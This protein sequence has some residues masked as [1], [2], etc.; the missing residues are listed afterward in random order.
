MDMNYMHQEKF[1]KWKNFIIII[2]SLLF[3]LLFYQQNTGGNFLL[4]SIITITLLA[5]N[6]YKSFFKSDILL[7]SVAFL[8]SGVAI[9]LYNSP[10]T[11]ITNILV[12]FTLVGSFY[13]Q[14]SS[15]YI[16]WINGMYTTLVAAFTL[17]FEKLHTETNNIKKK[18]TNYFYWIKTIGIPAIIVFIFMNLYKTGNPKFDA[19]LSQINFSFINFQCLVFTSLGYYLFYNITHPVSIE[20]A[21]TLDIDTKNELEKASLKTTNIKKIKSE[22]HLGVVLLVALNILIVLFLVTDVLYI[23]EI[24]QM[25]APQLSQQVHTGINALIISNVFAIVI[26]L[27]FFRGNINFSKKNTLLKKLT[28]IWIFLNLLMIC[29]TAIKNIEYINSFGLTY[30]R[31]GVLFF[32]LFTAIGL[33]T[34]YIKVI[35]IKNLWFLFRKNLQ[36]AFIVLVISSTLNWDKIVTFYNINYAE[37]LDLNYLINL[38]ENNTF[39]LKDYVE[40]NKFTGKQAEKINIK[41][42]NYLKDLKNNS[43]QEFVFDNYKIR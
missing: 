35:K 11:I 25:S 6:N 21:T 7:K 13:E 39:L 9:F 2:P 24:H 4:F 40:K 38:S 20:P 26:I 28:F 14:K 30:K 12:F 10:L 34:T 19:L 32:L 41:H 3:S 33:I 29:I 1:E 15:I 27:Y 16:N 5:F 43:W 36:I 23:S 18:K 17:Y 31:I 22:I 8:I 37:Q 42:K